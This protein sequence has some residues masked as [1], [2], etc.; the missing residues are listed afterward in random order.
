ME[1]SNI[2]R[3]LSDKM[4]AAGIHQTLNP[5]CMTHTQQ[6]K[7]DKMITIPFMQGNSDRISRLLARFN[8]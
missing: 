3:R 2:S 8:I 5:K 6:E 7:P 4:A 1:K